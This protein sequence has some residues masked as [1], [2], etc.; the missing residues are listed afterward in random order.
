MRE[1]SASIVHVDGVP[2]R[3]PYSTGTGV[4]DCD[5]WPVPSWP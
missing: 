4:L 5:G 2:G 3:S 1:R